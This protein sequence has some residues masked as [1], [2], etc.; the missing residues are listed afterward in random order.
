MVPPPSATKLL[1]C[2]FCSEKTPVIVV[3]PNCNLVLTP[4]KLCAPRISELFRGRLTFPTSIFWIIS[5]SEGAYS[6]FIKF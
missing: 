1:V 3:F 6:N 2:D 4:N 5:S